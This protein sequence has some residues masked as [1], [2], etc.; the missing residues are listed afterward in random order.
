M[1][2][3]MGMMTARRRL[4]LAEGVELAG[5]GVVV[6]GGEGDLLL[7]F[8]LQLGDG[9]GEV[10]AAHGEL[11]G[12]V[13]ASAFAIDHEAAFADGDV[14]DLAE[15]DA[16]SVG[17]GDE[18]G[19]DGFGCA[20]V[21][22]GVADGEVEAAVS[23]DDLG[24]GCSADGCLD[25]GVDVAGEDAEAG[26]FG[27]VDLDDERGLASDFEDADVGDAGDGLHDLLDLVGEAGE[28]V[29]VVAEE[30]EGV[31][32]LDAG[33]GFFD[34]VLDVL[35]E[36]EFDAGEAGEAAVHLVDE[37]RLGEAG[38][39]VFLRLEGDGDFDVVEGGD[40]G[41]VVGAAH[42]RDGL[43]D[44]GGLGDDGADLV[45]E[46]GG[47]VEGDVLREGGANPEVAFFERGHELAA[48]EDEAEDAEG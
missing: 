30:L 13:A 28:G 16:A 47:G 46:V 31:L 44:L 9:G 22:L 6:A 10:A 36:V 8:G 5:P 45:G 37:L 24:D 26:G 27:A 38:T 15:G 1:A 17:G 29:E 18:D 12:D 33:H 32:A 14:G 20:A 41:A 34:V 2:S 19:A 3:E 39:P 42:L 43:G 23:L 48:D 35:R 4:L 11:D 25:G 7:E 21:G 40:V